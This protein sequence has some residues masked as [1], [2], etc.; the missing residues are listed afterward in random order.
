MNVK[1]LVMSQFSVW[2]A[3]AIWGVYYLSPL[4]MASERARPIKFG[5]DLV[6]GTYISLIVD[7]DK[8]VEDALFDRIEDM[9]EH[10]KKAGIKAPKSV[11]VVLNNATVTFDSADDA[12][13][14]ADFIRTSD[15]GLEQ[16]LDGVTVTVQFSTA[17]VKHIHKAAV[18]GNIHVLQNRLDKFAV[19]EI[20][21]AAQ[22][23]KN[24]IVELPNVDDPAKAKAMIG[25]AAQLEICLVYAHGRSKEEIFERYDDQIP[26]GTRIV[27]SKTRGGDAEYY[28]ISRR[29]DL[30]G[31][32]LK[33][34][35]PTIDEFNR[36]AVGFE[37]VEE[38][39]RRFGELTSKN[40]GK[41][42]AIVFDS[43]VISA[44]TVNTRIGAR[45]V[46]TK[47]AGF[48]QAEAKE[49]SDFLKSGA[50]A[51]P[52]R[53]D[54]D[55]TIGP[56]LGAQAIKQGT[57]AC[58]VGIGALF[59]FSLLY[60]K[61]PGIFAFLTLLY[62]LLLLLL[63]LA[64]FGGTLTLPGIAGLVL[65]LGMAID[66]SILIYEKIKEELLTGLTLAR[67]IESG[68]TGAMVVILDANITTFLMG[69]V[70][71]KFG[72][73][74]IQGFAV[75]LMIGIVTTLITGL[76]FLRSLFSWVLQGFGVQRM[77]F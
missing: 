66:S 54:E 27:Q 56:S 11:N 73:G 45:G 46:I 74:P 51:A 69:V 15:L 2:I 48:S 40:I 60:Y 33:N 25:K 32:L 53:F 4:F 19:G 6:G 36:V 1:R 58:L 23:D 7:V 28:L 50:Y 65:T 30:T 14:C 55:R 44:P 10:F 43:E 64:Y 68:F 57:L 16:R 41:R 70:L 67:A 35:S 13:A 3:C 52:V 59:V 62:N 22:G 72:T 37:F 29:P 20:T 61:I 39:G 63:A 24:I 47:E 75:V 9:K 26:E 34:A 21:V 71:Y 5:I 38:G 76:F 17:R 31:K 8:A 77:K 18:E 49:L 12:L 42:I